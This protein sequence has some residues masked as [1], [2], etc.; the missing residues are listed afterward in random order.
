MSLGLMN[1][2]SLHKNRLTTLT[3]LVNQG[4]IS[5]ILVDGQQL[6]LEGPHRQLLFLDQN[7]PRDELLTLCQQ[8]SRHTGLELS[9]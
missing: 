2:D 7:T 9:T 1:V 6:F 4:S 8:F 5:H 3:D